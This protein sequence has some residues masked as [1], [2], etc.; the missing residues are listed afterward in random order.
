MEPNFG[1]RQKQWNI[2]NIRAFQNITLRKFTNAPPFVSDLGIK[3]AEEDDAVF[4]KRFYITLEYLENRQIKTLHIST[5][6]GNH[7]RRLE[8]KKNGV[9]II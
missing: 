4:C 7:S 9:V 3:T 6:S 5:L 1:N 8:K 2:N